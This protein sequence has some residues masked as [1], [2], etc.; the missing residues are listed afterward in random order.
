AYSDGSD[1]CG[2]RGTGFSAATNAYIAFEGGPKDRRERLAARSTTSDAD[3]ARQR[4]HGCIAIARG[5][6]EPF[7][8]CPHQ[9]SIAMIRTQAKKLR[10]GLM[11]DKRTAFAGVRNKGMKQQLSGL[12][13]QYLLIEPANQIGARA[14]HAFSGEYAQ[15]EIEQ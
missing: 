9:V 11:R 6:C 15:C 2:A 8:H 14:R 1:H 4:A 10:A 5:E 7:H 13:L 12:A 3:L